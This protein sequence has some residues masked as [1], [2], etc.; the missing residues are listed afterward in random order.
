MFRGLCRLHLCVCLSVC[1]HLGCFHP[2]AAANNS[3]LNTGSEPPV[4]PE[5]G[6]MDSVVI[7]CFG[8]SCRG[9]QSLIIHLTLTWNSLYSPGRPPALVS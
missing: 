5:V 6:S 4:G 7:L 9:D 2:L 3:V 8:G 1:A